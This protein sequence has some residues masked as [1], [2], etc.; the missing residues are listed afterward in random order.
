MIRINIIKKTIKKIKNILPIA[1]IYAFGF[2]IIETITR[3]IDIHVF[4]M[5]PIHSYTTFPQFLLTLTWTPFILQH[6]KIKNKYIRCLL[7][8]I[9]IYVC[10]IIG[11]NI[12]LYVFNYRAWHYTDNY[13]M[14]N[15]M[16]TF[17]YYPFWVGLYFV[18]NYAYKKIERFLNY[19]NKIY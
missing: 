5:R 15:G 19:Y 8:P 6:K 14:F 16:I 9:N 13:A 11:G 12:I 10:E 4:N 7:Y 2:G 3:Q 1:I 17:N 18:E